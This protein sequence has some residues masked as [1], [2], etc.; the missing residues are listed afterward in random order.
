ME[1]GRNGTL[2]LDLV[3]HSSEARVAFLLPVLI[4]DRPF[5]WMVVRSQSYYLE[6]ILAYGSSKTCYSLVIGSDS[7]R[8]D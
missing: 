6:H 8:T 3:R 4:E 7:F 5:M 1:T 2:E